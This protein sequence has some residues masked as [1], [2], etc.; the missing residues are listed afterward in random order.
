MNIKSNV[1][2]GNGAYGYIDADGNVIWCGPGVG[3]CSGIV[4]QLGRG[5]G[6]KKA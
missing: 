5:P 4:N 3:R 1:R 2:A 6:A